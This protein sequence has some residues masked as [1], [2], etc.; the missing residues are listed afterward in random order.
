MGHNYFGSAR[1][2]FLEVVTAQMACGRASVAAM[3][4]PSRVHTRTHVA[5]RL[6]ALPAWLGR[7]TMASVMQR[8]NVMDMMIMQ[9]Q[10]AMASQMVVI[11]V[12]AA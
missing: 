5:Q 12:M 4:P 1:S 7:D 8:T 11:P 9:M 2:T 3:L 10:M 6:V